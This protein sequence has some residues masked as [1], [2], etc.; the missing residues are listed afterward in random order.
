MSCAMM[1]QRPGSLEGDAS[2]EEE[3]SGLVHKSLMVGFKNKLNQ[4]L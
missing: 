2:E 1:C 3:P 4:N